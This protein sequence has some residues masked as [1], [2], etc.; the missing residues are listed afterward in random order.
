MKTILITSA[1]LLISLNLNAQSLGFNMENKVPL[2]F[3]P[4]LTGVNNY[5][6]AS[7]F[8]QNTLPTLSGSFNTLLVSFQTPIKKLHGGLGLYYLNNNSILKTDN[9]GLSY[10]FQTSLTEKYSLSIGTSVELLHNQIKK[11]LVFGDI[12]PFY[13]EPYQVNTNLGILVFSKNMFFGATVK[14]LSITAPI[15][16]T[17]NLGYRFNILN[18]KLLHVTPTL[19][20]SYQDSFQNLTFK[21]NTSYKWAHLTLGYREGDSFLFAA[22]VDI[23][24]FNINYGYNYVFI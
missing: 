21:V 12:Y 6:T 5:A 18:E 23:K 20:Y 15:Y 17:T 4:A 11:S 22:G 8:H 14:N 19:S 3:N 24:N 13:F 1:L 7:I 10:S 16:L 2:I 9:F